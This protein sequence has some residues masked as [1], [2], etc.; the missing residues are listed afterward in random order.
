LEILLEITRLADG[1]DFVLAGIL[2]Y[3]MIPLP[4]PVD[5]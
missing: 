3:P 5:R 2:A 4:P 1:T